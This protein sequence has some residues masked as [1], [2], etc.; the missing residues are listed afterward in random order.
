MSSEWPLA[1]LED[2]TDGTPITYGVVKP[3]VEC[4]NGVKFIR[5]GDIVAG[6]VLTNQLRTITREISSQYSRTL[7]RGGELLI[8]L[9][10]NPGE[11]AIVPVTLRSANI[12]RQVGLIRIDASKADANYVQFFLRSKV[13]RNLLLAHSK[14][15]VQQ[16]INLKDLKSVQLPLPP[17]PLQIAISYFMQNIDDRIALLRE[18]NDTLEA[19][20]QA[21]F[22]SWFVDFDPVRAK[23]EGLEPGALDV[24]TAELFPDSFEESNFGTVPKGWIVST[25]DDISDVGIGKTPPRKEAHWFSESS[26]D[27]QWVSIRDMGSSGAFLTETSEYLTVDAISRF[28]VRRVPDNTVLLSFKMTIGRVAIT[29]GEMTT[30]E[31]IAHFKINEQS[32]LASEYIYLHLKQ[33][34]YSRLSSTSSIADAVNSKT[35]KAIPILVP[36][37]G[38]AAAFQ[39]TVSVIFDRIKTVQLQAKTLTQLRDTLLPRLISGQLRL[40]EA[41]ANVDN[42]LLETV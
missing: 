23:A 33:F 6:R 11:V 13:G 29:S 22:K 19:I 35:V 15:S 31:A 26:D 2:L 21:L 1:R 9:V 12:A 28:N 18:T 42:A 27:V 30:N 39:R 38:V 14:G 41:E 25:L 17:Y 36:S 10:G 4:V 20:A 37:A 24:A 5:G 8:S 7:L 16:V 34:D 3:G 32:P 40:P